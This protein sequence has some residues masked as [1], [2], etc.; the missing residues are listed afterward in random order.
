MSFGAGFGDPPPKPFEVVELALIG[1]EDVGDDVAEV[2]QDPP[3]VGVAL[4]TAAQPRLRG[5]LDDR[6]G[7]RARLDHRAPGHDDER[8][9]DDGASGEV[10]D[11]D[12]LGFLV[13]RGFE[14][15]RDEIEFRQGVVPPM[16]R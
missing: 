4:G 16:D 8:I 10:E 11:G 2:D 1:C 7:D 14:Y 12:V 3:P 5:F 9:G 6:V 13:L 15:E